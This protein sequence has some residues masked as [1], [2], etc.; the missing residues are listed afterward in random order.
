MNAIIPDTPARPPLAETP[1]S[2]DE[3]DEYVQLSQRRKALAI[4]AERTIER[5]NIKQQVRQAKVRGRLRWII[6]DV[7]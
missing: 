4:A 1:Y 5:G 6:Q 2:E 3:G 7:R